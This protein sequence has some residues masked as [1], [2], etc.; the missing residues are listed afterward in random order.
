MRM[1]RAFCIFPGMDLM[2]LVF[3]G[4]IFEVTVV[5]LIGHSEG[6]FFRCGTVTLPP[7]VRSVWMV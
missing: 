2:C 3:G 6:R 4:E 5:G 7:P 1:T